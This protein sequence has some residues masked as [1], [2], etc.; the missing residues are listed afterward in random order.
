MLEDEPKCADPT[1]LVSFNSEAPHVR[2]SIL[3]F[4]AIVRSKDGGYADSGE[5]PVFEIADVQGEEGVIDNANDG[6]NPHI[7]S[8]SSRH[9]V[10]I[11][12]MS[13]AHVEQNDIPNQNHEGETYPSTFFQ[14]LLERDMFHLFPSGELPDLSG[15]DF[16]LE[17]FDFGN[18]NE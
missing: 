13:A 12:P 7:S 10:P 5:T 9:A 14:P 1:K 17:D 2:A 6:T 3:E 15:F 16:S 8:E 4:I 11:T 18:W